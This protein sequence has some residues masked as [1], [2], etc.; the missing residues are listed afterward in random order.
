MKSNPGNRLCSFKLHRYRVDERR[1]KNSYIEKEKHYRSNRRRA[2]NS[3]NHLEECNYPTENRRCLSH[4]Y[5]WQRWIRIKSMTPHT[6][7]FQEMPTVYPHEI[8]VPPV[9]KEDDKFMHVMHITN[10]GAD[11][12][13][14]IEKGI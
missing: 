10:V 8:V 6:L 13:W 7:Y 11:K 2:W 3:G 9:R 5:K 12:W 4:R 14:Y 1:H